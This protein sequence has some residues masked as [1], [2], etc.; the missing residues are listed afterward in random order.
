MSRCVCVSVFVCESMTRRTKKLETD[1]VLER[2]QN[3]IIKESEN[4]IESINIIVR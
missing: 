1:K 3:T 2:L 4:K